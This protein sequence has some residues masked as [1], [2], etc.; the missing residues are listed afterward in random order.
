MHRCEGSV[1]DRSPFA[2][3][4]VDCF[5]TELLYF[6][7]LLKSFNRVIK[8]LKH[9]KAHITTRIESEDSYHISAEARSA[10]ADMNPRT[11]YEY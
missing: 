3:A 5:F 6:F 9:G 4:C 11:R 8:M 7:H 10:E 1:L 2:L